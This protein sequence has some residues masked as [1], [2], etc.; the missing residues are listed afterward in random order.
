VLS[1]L[2]LPLLGYVALQV[3]CYGAQDCCPL[4][5]LLRRNRGSLGL[6]RALC[7]LRRWLWLLQQHRLVHC[8]SRWCALLLLLRQGPGHSS[9]KR[10]ILLLLLLQRQGP[11][12][13]CSRWCFSV[14]LLLLLR[15][16]RG[17]ACRAR[18]CLLPVLCIAKWLGL[19]AASALLL[20][21]LLLYRLLLLVFRC[22]MLLQTVLMPPAARRWRSAGL[23]QHL[24]WDF[25]I[26]VAQ[27]NDHLVC[28]WFWLF[29]PI[30]NTDCTVVIFI[31]HVCW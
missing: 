12:V 29:V 15:R 7:L 8:R 30:E 26:T 2:L 1:I 11:D 14:L 9:S 22:R 20:S 10:C 21:V 6:M 5:P 31:C 27:V 23:L 28:L 25:F 17:C 16:W 4:L 13:C 24:C 3:V 19:L 18:A